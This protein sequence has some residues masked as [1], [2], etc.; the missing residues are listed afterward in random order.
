MRD[1]AVEHQKNNLI[2]EDPTFRRKVAAAQMLSP[3]LKNDSNPL[4]N[5][6]GTF[7][8]AGFANEA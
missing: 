7:P 6:D 2:E 5:G 1:F 3:S 4:D 8:P